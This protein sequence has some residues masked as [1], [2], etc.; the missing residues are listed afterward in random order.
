M[1]EDI[2]LP[3]EPTSLPLIGQRKLVVCV[4]GV[5]YTIE[6]HFV[7]F[8]RKL[9]RDARI[10]L[11]VSDYPEDYLISPV[12]DKLI[13]SNII[14]SYSFLP[15]PKHMWRHH[16]AV[17]KACRLFKDEHVDLLICPSDFNPQS[18]YFISAARLTNTPV[19]AI[20]SEA[21]THLLASYAAVTSEERIAE[22]A[23]SDSFIDGRFLRITK[24]LVFGPSRLQMFFRLIAGLKVLSVLAVK[25]FLNFEILPILLSRQRFNKL[26]HE[27][28]GSVRFVTTRVDAAIVYRELTR[29]ALRYFAPS[30]NVKVAAHPLSENC[31]CRSNVPVP[32]ILLVLFGGPWSH[33][34]S[35]ENPEDSIAER[36]FDAI[37]QAQS[38]GG[39]SEIHL[40]PHPRETNSYPHKLAAK[41]TQHGTNVRVM[42]PSS[43]NIASIICDYAGLIAAPSGALTEAVNACRRVFVVALDCIEGEIG[44]P[45]PGEYEEDIV[46]IEKDSPI[47][48]EHFI[49]TQPDYERGCQEV[50]PTV[51]ERIIR[52]AEWDCR[53]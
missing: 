14:E 50:L 16:R 17:T 52:F 5:K 7:P 34:I 31:R 6:S 44:M 42:D 23:K 48:Q 3:V 51:Y 30:M 9:C 26:K 49:R 46:V 22:E 1:T 40:R 41:L 39:F 35:S 43:C 29:E 27:R 45:H 33:Y 20:E 10:K 36:W 12:L 2:E 53:S 25:N 32:R 13:S 24:I 18:R 47:K 37:K 8:L 4:P 28:D 15:D 19:L 11:C 38:I 21:Q